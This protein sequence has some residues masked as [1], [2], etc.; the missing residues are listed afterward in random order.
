ML[1]CIASFH[2]REPQE[3]RGTKELDS[4]P[5]EEK[6]KRSQERKSWIRA[7]GR[8]ILGEVRRGRDAFD[9]NRV[10]YMMNSIKRKSVIEKSNTY[11]M[12]R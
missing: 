7:H 6:I 4:S 10:K 11:A 5:R 12:L 1:F 8:K 9:P 2:K 3:N